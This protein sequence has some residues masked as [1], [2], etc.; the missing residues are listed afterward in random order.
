MKRKIVFGLLLLVGS[1][2]FCEGMIDEDY[3]LPSTPREDPVIK[4]LKES[5]SSEWKKCHFVGSLKAEWNLYISKDCEYQYYEFSTDD[6]TLFAKRK[7]GKIEEYNGS[8]SIKYNDS[9]N[10]GFLELNFSKVFVGIKD[11]SSQEGKWQD[12]NIQKKLLFRTEGTIKQYTS[13]NL[14][15]D[16]IKDAEKPEGDFSFYFFDITDNSGFSYE[17]Y[18][19][20]DM[21]RIFVNEKILKCKADSNA[22]LKYYYSSKYEYGDYDIDPYYSNYYQESLASTYLLTY[23]R[24]DERRQY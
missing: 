11:T 8:Y 10:A 21:D 9:N 23:K 5:Q 18:T 1:L 7:D 22:A 15:T 17:S 2:L 4:Q 16:D 12:I 14:W 20:Y 13:Y 3:D 6:F 24:I 19:R